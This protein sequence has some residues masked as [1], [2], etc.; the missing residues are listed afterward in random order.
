MLNFPQKETSLLKRNNVRTKPSLHH[1]NRKNVF[2]RNSQNK[3]NSKHTT[4]YIVLEK[5]ND[6][7]KNRKIRQQKE[8]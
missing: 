2:G 6:D 8:T 1:P 4:K 7:F 3:K 5:K